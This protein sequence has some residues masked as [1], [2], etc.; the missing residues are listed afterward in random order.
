MN[1]VTISDGN[2]GN[3]NQTIINESGLYALILSSQLPPR[4]SQIVTPLKK[5]G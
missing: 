3:P 1:T 5:K 2:R 4:V